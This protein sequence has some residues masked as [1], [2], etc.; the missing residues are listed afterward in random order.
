MSVEEFHISKLVL[1]K[2]CVA[3]INYHKAGAATR[4]MFSITPECFGDIASSAKAAGIKSVF[5][6]STCNRTEIYGIAD[7]VLQLVELLVPHTRG[8]K[9]S[10]FEFGYFKSGEHALDHIFNVAAGLDSQ[11]LGDYEILG[12][13]KR[14]VDLSKKY[15]LVGPVMDRILNFV[16]QASKKIKTETNLSNGTVSV[17]FAAIELLQ[18]TPDIEN[19]A[20]LVIGAGKFGSTVCK[21]LKTYLPQTS[22]TI[23]NR[24][25]ETARALGEANKISFAR[26]SEISAEIE[27]ADI[28][29][30]CTNA[31]EPT[32]FPDYFKP[33][34]EKIILDLSVPMNVHPDVKNASGIKVTDVDQISKSILDRTL[35][36]RKA[37][38][39][40]AQAIIDFYKKE[41][42]TWL[43]EYHYALHLKTWKAKLNEIDTLHTQV[44]EFYNDKELIDETER[45]ARAQKAVKQLAVN[46]KLRNDKGCQFISIINDYL[47]TR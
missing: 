46:L 44:C 38:V 41:F 18:Q 11:I 28:V 17:S 40:K 6:I 8:D 39:P 2:F 10:F 16:Y 12:Q 19:R 29:V 31:K 20:V 43:H 24:T 35:A 22:V 25:D 4:G 30:V 47:Q 27:K 13:L 7:S 33:G 21:N 9:N 37:E 36:I 14:A 42:S 15:R 26:Y 1:D 23:M 32:V 3:G 45:V 5:V 34:A